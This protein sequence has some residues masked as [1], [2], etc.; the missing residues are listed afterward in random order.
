[1]AEGGVTRKLTAI[2]Y[3]DVAGYSRLTGEDELGTHQRLGAAL[4]LISN[5][6]K[7]KGG[8]VVHY[9]GDAVLADFVSVVAA[10][11]CGESIQRQLTAGNADVPDDRTLRFRIGINLGEVI[12]DRDDIYGDGVNVAARLESLADPGGICI[13]AAVYEQVRGKVDLGFEDMGPQEVKNISEPV[14]AY[15]VVLNVDVALASDATVEPGATPALPD[16][17]SIAVLPFD[18]MSGDAEQ[19]YFADGIAED[20]ITALSKISGLF[21]IARNS[22]FTHKGR[23]VNVQEA[24]REFGVRHIV[25]GSVRKAG[26]RVRISAQLIDGQ[27]GGHLWAEQ[28]DRD[29]EDIFAVQDEVTQHIVSALE[30]TLKTGEGERL[31]QHETANLACYDYLLRGR[32]LFM[33]FTKEGIQQA[34]EAFERAVEIDPGCA[35]GYA[36][37]AQTYMLASIMGHSANPQQAAEM[38]ESFADKALALDEALP[39]AHGV[40]GYVLLSRKKIDRAIAEMETWIELDPS[41]A[42]AY[43]ALAQALNAAGRAEAALTAL[44]T[45][46]RHNPNFGFLTLFN[47][48]LS[49]FM[50]GHYADAIQA[51]ESSTVRNPEFAP[52]MLLLA[53]SYAEAG[54]AKKAREALA[55]VERRSPELIGASIQKFVPF[56]HARH[57]EDLATALS[58]A[59]APE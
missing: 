48:G 41:E 54:E 27:T 57:A 34:R 45:S 53:A 18:N 7:G 1:M 59:R 44:D 42:D 11:E 19:E 32:E 5:Q 51:L 14:R 35:P 37:L 13:S 9:A 6:I 33:R 20:I 58:K 46:M 36:R 40:K 47:L 12:V 22:T 21:V 50:L 43:L 10:V 31:V 8:T 26:N 24:S 28:Y 39:L 15:R 49:H 30:V 52:A 25:E 55:A 17:P 2:L 16:K 23:A 38:A 29:L 4:D 3:A 56:M